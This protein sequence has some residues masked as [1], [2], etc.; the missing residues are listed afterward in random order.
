ML[1]IRLPTSLEAIALIFGAQWIGG[2]P[3]LVSPSEPEAYQ[4][5]QL[6]SLDCRIVVAESGG[7]PRVMT[8]AAL[9]RHGGTAPP[10]PVSAPSGVAY[11]QRTSGTT[12]DP[13]AA[14][15]THR[16]LVAGVQAIGVAVEVEASDVLV[17]WLPLFHD[18]GLVQ[19]V[20][21]PV[22][23]GLPVH[24]LQPKLG[25]IRAWLR[26]VEAVGA[27]VTGAPDFAYRL[28]TRL[29]RNETVDVSSL[30]HAGSGGEP[31]RSSTIRA[32][33]SR[34]SV[35]GVV[36]PG[37]GLGETTLAVCVAR[38]G[39]P[40]RVDLA[41][42]VSCGPPLPGYEVRIL[43][44]GTAARPHPTGE[45]LVR[46]AGVFERY[47]GATE[48]ALDSDGWFRT[49]DLG[50]LDDLG[51]LHVCGRVRAM[52][53]R[54]GALIPARAVEEI[55]DRVSGVRRS[56]ALG[57]A[58]EGAGEDLVVVAEARRSEGL[59]RTIERELSERLGFP[60]RRVV[61]V[62]PRTLPLT[63]SGK[64]RYEAIRLRLLSGEF[65]QLES[66]GA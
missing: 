30:R 19:F 21:F 1:A 55:V 17:S 33:E 16:N 35:P 8:L 38:V 49:G 37:Y 59:A 15:L 20:F 4:L 42:N 43:E 13:K 28:A 9:T 61:L 54:A 45:I 60:P 3:V 25:Q 50:Y 44:S 57:C 48:T 29:F 65:A 63:G 23:Y 27:T 66:G 41:G 26:L 34:F 14:S 53:K 24:L 51:E 40:L 32:F 39:S 12:G 18:Y 10:E 31:V 46:G 47:F 11:L 22:Y 6:A 36:R 62:P 2:I 5:R 58:D 64:L 7:D 52:I 56:A